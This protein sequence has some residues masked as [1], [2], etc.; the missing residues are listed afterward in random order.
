[1]GVV[2]DLK[3]ITSKLSQ[4][5]G[6]GIIIYV[7]IFSLALLL[8]TVYLYEISDSPGFSLLMGDS[9]FYDTWALEI[10]GGDWIGNE[11]F[12]SGPLYPY[13]LG[14]IYTIFGRNLLVVRIIQILLGAT[15]CILLAL[16]GRSFF[17]KRTGVI[18]GILLAAYPSAI[19]FDCLIQ[20]ATFSLFLITLLLML[21]G[22]IITDSNS[23]LWALSGIVLGFFALVR[24]NAFILSCV[25]I[26]WMLV[27]FRRESKKKLLVS[28]TAL[29]LGIA[30]VL[31]PVA[32]RN[33]IVAD[34]FTLFVS[35]FGSNLYMGNNPNAKGVYSPLITDRC[36]I[37]Y[38]IEDDT[39]QAEKDLGR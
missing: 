20:K 1:M 22:K 34:D 16:A 25:I 21:L 39:G 30:I 18:S 6:K 24:P 36:N 29:I 14:M 5:L 4:R 27:Y 26:L 10:A 2:I 7:I 9:E 28:N 3:M 31:F 38:E 11:V 23:K 35:N 37:K 15:S 8:R 33:K 12:F 32:L 19:Y 17:S 13:S